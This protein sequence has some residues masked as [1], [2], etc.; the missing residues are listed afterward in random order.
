MRILHY[1]C[2][3]QKY[4]V[5]CIV[6]KIIINPSSNLNLMYHTT[7]RDGITYIKE[8]GNIHYVVL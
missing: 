7:I 6:S 3:V 5:K 1:E 8:K 2:T 4:C